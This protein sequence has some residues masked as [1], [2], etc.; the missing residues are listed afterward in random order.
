MAR[1]PAII[2]SL[3]H[4]VVS[5]LDPGFPSAHSWIPGFRRLTRD[6]RIPAH[7][8]VKKIKKNRKNRFFGLPGPKS[9]FE[10]QLIFYMPSIS[11]INPYF[12]A[13]SPLK[14]LK[15]SSR[16][17]NLPRETLTA[18]S[19]HWDP[20]QTWFTSKSCFFSTFFGHV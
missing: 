6:S 10:I 5:L 8:F 2:P 11:Y 3:D 17:H 1:S 4:S 9:N 14:P 12:R 7:F 15:S 13:T 20:F 16:Y 19:D 18:H